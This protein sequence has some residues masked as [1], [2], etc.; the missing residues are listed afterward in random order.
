[1]NVLKKIAWILGGVVVILFGIAMYEGLEKEG[2]IS[3]ERTVDLYMTSDWLVG[4]S[5]A[6]YL[7]TVLDGQREPTGKI[8]ALRCPV[9]F[10]DL[11]E[12]SGEVTFHGDLRSNDITGKPIALPMWWTCTRHSDGFSCKVN[13][14]GGH[15]EAQ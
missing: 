15:G 9:G 3:H 4:E 14:S 10:R 7:A 6:C 12:H 2:H 8:E 11:E 1:M 5:R 13:G